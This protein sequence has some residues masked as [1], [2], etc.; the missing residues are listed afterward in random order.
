MDSRIQEGDMIIAISEDDDTVRLSG[1]KDYKIDTRAIRDT[2][3]EPQQ[4]ERTLILGWNWRVPTIICELDK[5]VAEGSA[6]AVVSD[7]VGASAEISR[8][9][10][11]LSRQQVS[12]QSGDPTDRRT[13]DTLEIPSYDHVIIQCSD[14]LDPQAADAR[15]LVTLL[16][17]RDIAARSGHTFSIVSE[18]LDV[19]NRALAEVTRADDFIVSDKLVSLMLSQ[20]SENKELNAVFADL[21]DPEGSEIYIK[22]V[23]RYVTTGRPVNFYTVLEAG[24]RRNEVA[25]GYKIGEHAGDAAQAYGV[26]VNPEKSKRVTFARGDR[27]IVLAEN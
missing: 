21:F 10:P 22:P 12:F 6:V 3:D 7:F 5:Y 24:R 25:I 8:R 17:L 4:A 11:D 20:I 13:L 18:M 15:T 16:H 27:I 2:P 14:R 23:E 26:V 19:R 9:C 1:L